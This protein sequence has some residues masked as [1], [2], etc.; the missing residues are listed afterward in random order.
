MPK[1]LSESEEL[2]QLYH[3]N[4]RLKEMANEVVSKMAKFVNQTTV[5]S[6]KREKKQF[7][8]EPENEVVIQ[9]T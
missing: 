7:K 6:Q 3:Q 1:K 5:L 4:I 9:K 8:K 2:V